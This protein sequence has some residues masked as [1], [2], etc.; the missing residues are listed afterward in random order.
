MN[1]LWIIS[2]TCSEV[3]FEY[4]LYDVNNG[5]DIATFSAA[6]VEEGKKGAKSASVQ[7]PTSIY[8]LRLVFLH[9]IASDGIETSSDAYEVDFGAAPPEKPMN[10]TGEPDKT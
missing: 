3:A 6:D 4:R 1:K 5:V 7:V 9:A 2:W 10:V 8:G